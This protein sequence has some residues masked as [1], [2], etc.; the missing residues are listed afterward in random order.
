[1][2]LRREKAK[3]LLYFFFFINRIVYFI[4]TEDNNPNFASDIAYHNLDKSKS[5][6]RNDLLDYHYKHLSSD[7]LR[8]NNITLYGQVRI[9][10][11]S[12][13]LLPFTELDA[14]GNK[15]NV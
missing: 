5:I 10:E 3:M 7:S 14:L 2:K 4:L 11:P 1:M 13:S 8:G 12:L 15:I 6:T 9:E